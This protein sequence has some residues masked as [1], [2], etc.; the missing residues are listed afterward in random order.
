MKTLAPE[1][2]C[3]LRPAVRLTV[4]RE[5]GRPHRRHNC[6]LYPCKQPARHPECVDGSGPD[7][8]SPMLAGRRQLSL[9]QEEVSMRSSVV[10]SLQPAV[11]LCV[12]TLIAGSAFGQS[13]DMKAMAQQF[14]Q[15]AKANAAALRMY[16]W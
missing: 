7:A 13:Q 5:A 2:R 15:S 1:K 6:Q 9:K 14:G 3:A 10:R 16:S 12:L 11:L 8:C 4:C